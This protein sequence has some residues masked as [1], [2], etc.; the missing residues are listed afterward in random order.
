MIP[1]FIDSMVFF[2]DSLAASVMVF[3]FLLGLMAGLNP[4]PYFFFNF[5]SNSSNLSLYVSI[6]L[7]MLASLL[8]LKRR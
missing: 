5:L 2:I 6:I 4:T 1:L 7:S 8:G 3:F